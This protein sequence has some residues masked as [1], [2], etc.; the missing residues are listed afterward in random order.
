M[1]TTMHQSLLADPFE[2][3]LE[4][5]AAPA[6]VRAIER[7]ESAAALWQALA[8]SGFLDAL[9]AEDRGGAGL[10]LRDVHPLM[11][12]CGRH[13]LPV[14]FAQTLLARSI[15]ERAG[16]AIPEGPIILGRGQA[17]A[18]GAVQCVNISHGMTAQWALVGVGDKAILLSVA[19]AQRE[20][21]ASTHL[22]ASLTWP[23]EAIR[24]SVS[25]MAG[26]M[27]F[28]VMEACVLAPMIA[29]AMS[30]VFRL[31]LQYANDRVQFGRSLSKFQAIQ[32]YIAVMA[33]QTAL[34]RTAGR[35]GCDV[36][37]VVPDAG[38]VSLAKAITSETAPSVAALGHAIHGAIGV[39][40]EF[41]LQLYTRRLHEWRLCAG[42]EV[43]WNERIGAA[44]IASDQDRLLDYLI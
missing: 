33:E 34:A 12:L 16:V 44:V 36:A 41:D 26:A 43:F 8:E 11:E 29:G 15:L 21:T 2:R 32:H 4:D 42:S 37:G 5:Q 13:A 9:R 1:S 20:A 17:D 30:T 6:Q 25:L 39:T 24:S 27:D 18:T 7:G 3:L 19:S 38:K 40:A 10:S 23:A 14:P 35:M 28:R 22:A 31:T